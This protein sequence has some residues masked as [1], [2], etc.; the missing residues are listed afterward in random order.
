MAATIIKHVEYELEAQVFSSPN[1]TVAEHTSALA[2]RALETELVRLEETETATETAKDTW[3]SHN[4]TLELLKL[5][6]M[7]LTFEPFKVS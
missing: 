5:P 2:K 1:S 6:T 4:K 7:S 3:T